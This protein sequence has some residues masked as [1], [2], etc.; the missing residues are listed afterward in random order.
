MLAERVIKMSAQTERTEPLTG[1]NYMI[2]ATRIKAIL[3]SKELYKCI[4]EDGEP[5]TTDEAYTDCKKKNDK[6]YEI[7][8]LNLLLEQSGQ[9]LNKEKAKNIWD[10]LKSI[11]MG[12]VEN[13]RI[14][15][16]AKLKNVK[17]KEK[18]V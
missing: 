16:G 11:L 13:Q 9:F 1:S 18:K 2:W 17:M 8:V 4:L 5:D 6:V 7:I 3:K 14:D 10:K 12:R 15:I